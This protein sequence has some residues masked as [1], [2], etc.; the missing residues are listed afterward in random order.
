VCWQ[1]RGC[2]VTLAFVAALAIPAP[3]RV[4]EQRAAPAPIRPQDDLFGH[5]NGSWLAS[6]A[7]PP[8]KVTYGTLIELAD[9][10]EADLRAL[11]EEIVA[12]GQARRGSIAQQVGDLY[13]SLMDEARIESLGITPIKPELDGIYTV[14]SPSE[15]AAASGRISAIGGGGPFDGTVDAD[16]E[17]GQLVVRLA[18]SGILLPDRDYY[19]ADAPQYRRARTAYVEYLVRIL[20]LIGRPDAQREAEDVLA[21]ETELAR[22]QWSQAEGR[23]P[24]KTANRIA[25]SD[26]PRAFPGFDWREWAKPQGIDR[27]ETV[28][29][30]QPSFFKRF[31]ELSATTPLETWKAWLAARYITSSAPFLSRAFADARFDFFGK[32]LS[33]QEVPRIR[34]R[35]AVSLVSG[36]LGDAVGRLYVQKHFPPASKARVERLVSRVIEAFGEAVRESDWM[37]APTKRKALAKL[38]RLNTRIG[39]PSG[40]RDYRGLEIERDDL[41]GNIQR[42][43][44]F[45]HRDQLARTRGGGSSDPWAVTPQTVNAYYSPALNELVVT[46]AMLQPPIFDPAADDAAN[47]G[48]IGAIVGHEISHGFD[49]RGRFHD[50][51]GEVVDWWTASDVAAFA[52]RAR[53]LVEQFNAYSPAPGLRV[54]GELTLSENIAD[55]AGLSIAFRAYRRT[56]EGKPSRAIDGR[57]GEQRF[58]RSWAIAWRGTMRDEYRHQWLLFSPHAP[59]RYR[60][61]GPASN[62]DGFHEAFGVGPGD[63]LFRRPGER[64]RLW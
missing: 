5:V 31:A 45:Q 18:Q 23:D 9:K 32:E 1:L 56:L 55:L 30:A 6:T 12:A 17:S 16:A 26:L 3:A 29:V 51:R 52:Q 22:A 19:L 7:I 33:G 44:Q 24:L 59:P 47:Y 21:L 62:L 11:I 57:S 13:A 39:Y 28:V 38:S 43:R 60:V 20:T 25:F 63:R 58:F 40:W 49:D 8:E 34:W 4:Q 54:N 27:L 48:A 61:N 42:A 64:V 35:R 37:A 14:S 46:A 41:F 15:F 2:A 36:Y 10:V 50:E 53:A